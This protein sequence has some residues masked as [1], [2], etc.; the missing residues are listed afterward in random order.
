RAD[1]RQRLERNGRIEGSI[2]FVQATARLLCGCL[3][4]DDGRDS[5]C[6]RQTPP[7]PSDL[8]HKTKVAAPC[9]GRQRY[10]AWKARIRRKSCTV[11]TVSVS[12]NELENARLVNGACRTFVVQYFDR[13]FDASPVAE[14][15][16]VSGDA[17]AIR[18]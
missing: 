13:A 14:V 12:R 16:E 4:R 6:G 11:E 2:E 18:A 3:T 5:Q 1:V 17:A 8:H 9:D 10:M 15:N 7:P